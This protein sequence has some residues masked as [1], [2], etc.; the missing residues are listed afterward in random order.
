MDIHSAVAEVASRFQYLADKKTLIGDW[1]F[2]MPEHKGVMRGDCDDFAVTALWK[3]CD[4]S[5]LKFILN[6]LILHRFR[7]YYSVTG[8]G[9]PHIIGY[10][11]GLWFDNWSKQ[12][13][14]LSTFKISTGH[15]IKWFYPSPVTAW[16]LLLGLFVRHRSVAK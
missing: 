12:P 7:L 11:D 8:H 6:V 14:D 15:S 10:A 2:V 13:L 16:Y 5:L 3:R 1:W 4:G 9:E